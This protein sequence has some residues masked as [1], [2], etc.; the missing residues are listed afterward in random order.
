[1]G[2]PGADSAL[3]GWA[4]PRTAPA[5]TLPRAPVSEPR[6][7]TVLCLASF[8]KGDA[9]LRECRRLGC[10]V[11][12]LTVERLR[13]AAWPREAID[14]VFHMPDLYRREDVVHGVSW[15]ARTERIDRIVPLDE[16]D[17]EMASTLR[18][19][20]RV[21]GMGETT[22]RH[23]RDKLAMRMKAREEGILVPDFVP[24][25]NHDAL[26]EFMARVPA[27]WVLK[28]RFSASAIGIRKLDHADQLWPLLD[29]LGDRQSFHLLERFVPGDV[30][31]VDALCADREVRFAEASA[32]FQPPFE[33][34]HG[35]GVFSTRTIDR[36][37]SA[38]VD[39]LMAA[40]ARVVEALGLVRGALHTEFIRGREDGRLYF[41][42]TAARVGGAYIVDMVEAATGI[43]LWREWARLEVADARGE[44]YAPPDA[45][46]DHAGLLLSLAR[47][48]WP[49]M[50]AY[51]DPEIVRRLVKRHHAGLIVASPRAAR[52]AEL[53]GSYMRRFRED[54]YA[55]MPA[56]EEAVE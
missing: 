42:E 38:E 15:L 53:L 13:D 24:V 55:A 41:L 43:D 10:R 44:P 49:D 47:Q 26:R 35:G 56:L 54:F 22:V 30:L 37:S 4:G 2:A 7:V 28:P 36:D 18:E 33:V 11:L 40:N 3:P 9:F 19:H 6:P 1:M 12:L 17:L 20:L 14:E 51:D 39:D 8:F 45:R 34:Y 48:E 50:G 5:S 23:F 32:Y 21:P 25:L 27:P 52:V 16:F 46:H 31:H 29:E